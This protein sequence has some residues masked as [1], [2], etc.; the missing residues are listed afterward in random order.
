MIERSKN[1]ICHICET[2]HP[3]DTTHEKILKVKTGETRHGIS[4]AT[5]VGAFLGV[6][7]SSRAITS[8]MFNNNSRVYIRNKT[9]WECKD[10]HDKNRKMHIKNVVKKVLLFAILFPLTIVGIY[11]ILNGVL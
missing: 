5:F 7:S 6:K 1:R 10:C 9:V 3:Q 8:W 2:R 4:F 11:A